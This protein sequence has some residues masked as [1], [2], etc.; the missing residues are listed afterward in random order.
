MK[1]IHA[2]CLATGALSLGACTT[3][4]LNAFAEGMAQAQYNSPLYGNTYSPY[5]T[6][7]YG[8]N[9][10]LW[11]GYNQCRHTGSFYQCDTNGD[12]YS[13]SYGNTDDGSY[14]SSHL[15][16]NGRGEGFTRGENGEWVRN[17]AYDTSDRDDHHRH[18]RRNRHDHD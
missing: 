1:P 18:H 2:I 5:G 7:R 9:N 4:D 12:G 17:R 8:N 16:V 15:R 6:N 3:A 13:D 14:S 11:V 10:T